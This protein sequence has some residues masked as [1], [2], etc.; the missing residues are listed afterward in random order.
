MVLLL[1]VSLTYF[2]LKC[3]LDHFNPQRVTFLLYIDLSI[4]DLSVG[5]RQVIFCHG[6]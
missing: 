3:C 1:A 4:L 5:G 6:S 2:L